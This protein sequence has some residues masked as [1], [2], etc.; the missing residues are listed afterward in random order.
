MSGSAPGTSR[1]EASSWS[2][3]DPGE[4]DRPDLARMDGAASTAEF[5]APT[6]FAAAFADAFR[7]RYGPAIDPPGL[8][9]GQGAFR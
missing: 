1:A 2:V 4:G 8:R 6:P 5:G 7:Y 3:S 9:A